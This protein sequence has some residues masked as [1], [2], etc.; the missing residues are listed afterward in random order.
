ML[1]IH[2]RINRVDNPLAKWHDM[3]M[4][5][6]YDAGKVSTKENPPTLEQILASQPLNPLRPLEFRV[7]PLSDNYEQPA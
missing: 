2:W 7:L 1:A 4:E 6:I 5:E 3:G